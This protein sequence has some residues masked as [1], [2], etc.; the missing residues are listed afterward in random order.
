MAESASRGHALRLL[1]GGAV[2]GVLA[3][4]VCLVVFGLAMGAPAMP[5]VII[6]GVTTLVFF[7]SGQAVQV[8]TAAAAAAVALAAALGSYLIR[9]AGVAVVLIVAQP[10]AADA[11]N[12]VLVPTMIA[13]VVGW[14]AAEIWT[15]TRLRVMV[16]D[17][18]AEG[19][20]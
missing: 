9:A 11:A 18:P 16:F 1:A 13:V 14:L 10:F 6:G 3:C 17:P 20:S 15:F 8:L 12:P 19:G 4:V 2:G 5:W 7:A